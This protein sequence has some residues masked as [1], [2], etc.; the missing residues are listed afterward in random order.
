MHRVAY[1]KDV[2]VPV[3]DKLDKF[4]QSSTRRSNFSSR[5]PLLDAPS[6]GT[7]LLKFIELNYAK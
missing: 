7:R 4:Q 3:L 1:F 2:C 6:A 5:V